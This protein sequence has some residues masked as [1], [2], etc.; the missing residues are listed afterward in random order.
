MLSVEYDLTLAHTED[1]ATRVETLG[2][3]EEHPFWV[4]RPGDDEGYIWLPAGEL[5]AG[6][7]LSA[8]ERDGATVRLDE[9]TLTV[10]ANVLSGENEPVYNLTVE[11][12][13]TYAVGYLNAQVH[14]TC[15]LGDDWVPRDIQNPGSRSG[16]EECALDIQNKIGGDIVRI[17]PDG[18]PSLG[19]YRGKNWEWSHH[20][21][22]VRDGRVYDAF[23]PR[24]GLS[25]SDYKAQF[26][27]PEAINFGF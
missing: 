12:F 16:C 1:G 21:V 9:G 6:D 15:D 3:T 10:S 27:Y 25:I 18:A 8:V 23:G 4:D 7:V 22:V 19:G 2:V 5:R 26:Q 24:G 14:N 17:T 13:H 20:D 11:D